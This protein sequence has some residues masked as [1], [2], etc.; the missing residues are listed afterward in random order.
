MR[1]ALCYPAISGHAA[2]SWRALNTS[3][4]IDLQIIAFGPDSPAAPFDP[5]IVRDLPITLLDPTQQQDAAFIARKVIDHRPDIVYFS[6]W[7]HRPYVRLLDQPELAGAAFVM[8]ADTQLRHNLRQRL[9]R[10]K[11]Q[12]LLRRLDG[13]IVAGERG[14]ELMRSWRV[15]PHKVF[16]GLYGMD[17]AAFSTAV[18]R[19]VWPR[20]FLYVGRYV[21]VKGVDVL[22][23]AYRRYRDE[24]NDPWTLTCCGAG[25]EK[26]RL[27]GVEGVVDRGF[28]QPAALPAE[29]RQAGV[30]LQPSLYEPWCVSIAEG[31]VAGLPVICS[32]ACGVASDV[33]RDYYNGIR[34]P[35]GDAA[36]L[37]D[38]MRWMHDHAD[39]L[40]EMGRRG[41]ELALA[42]SAE[43]FRE[44]WVQMFRQLLRHRK[45][46]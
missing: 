1:V 11:V 12:P 46:A 35:T 32:E 36:A 19:P 30:L 2:A 17:A 44:R 18:E 25:P 22:I 37:A 16:R 15:P 43:Q 20:N 24:A 31:A 13:V 42:F 45:S 34:V 38:A 40:P 21:P 41:R 3:P 33:L 29:M 23:D 26:A 9:G 4:E 27:A 28:V 6:G 8:G 14:T 10:W 7:G 39:Q 5:S